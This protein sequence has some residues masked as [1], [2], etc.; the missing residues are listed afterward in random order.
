MEG[1]SLLCLESSGPFYTDCV[2]SSYG[3][4]SYSS[5]QVQNNNQMTVCLPISATKTTEHVYPT[6]SYTCSGTCLTVNTVSI[7]Y[8][9]SQT[10]F[11]I[12]FH[13]RVRL[14]SNSATR[15]VTASLVASNGST[16]ASSVAAVDISQELATFGSTDSGCLNCIYG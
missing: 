10:Y 14:Y 11:Q 9:T 15:S 16:L 8:S 1:A 12:T 13:L 5:I 4:Q 3:C 6:P 7:S 2:T